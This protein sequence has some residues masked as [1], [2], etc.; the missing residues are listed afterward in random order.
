VENGEDAASVTGIV[1]KLL[2]SIYS[3]HVSRSCNKAAR[4]SQSVDHVIGRNM[5]L[6]LCGFM[7]PRVDPRHHL[8]QTCYY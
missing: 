4:V 3:S 7:I 5:F 2:S 6:V 8:Q 1:L